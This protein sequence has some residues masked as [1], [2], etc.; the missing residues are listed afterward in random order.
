[1]KK[2]VLIFILI[3]VTSCKTETEKV[4]YIVFSG[5]ITNVGDKVFRLKPLDST[6]VDLEIKF[7]QNGAFRDTITTTKQRFVLFQKYNNVYFDLQP[8]DNFSMT[9]DGENFLETI[10]FNGSGADIINYN[11]G[12]ENLTSDYNKNYRDRFSVDESDFKKNAQEFYN[13]TLAYL[14]EYSK[15]SGEIVQREKNDLFY[16]YG[17]DL[18]RYTSNHPRLAEIE[19][20]EVTDEFFI[21]FN[22]FNWENEAAYESSA[23]YRYLIRANLNLNFEKAPKVEGADEMVELIEYINQ[24]IQNETI[25]NKL[26]MQN[27]TLNITYTEDLEGLYKAFCDG[28]TDTE[29]KAEITKIY[30]N[31]KK[32]AK[33]NPS[34]KFVDYENHSGG[35]TSLDDLKGK[36]VYVDVWATWCGPCKVEIPFLKEVEKKYHGKNIEFVSISV[37]RAPDHEKWIKMVNDEELGGIQLYADKDWNSDFVT[38]YYIKGI[39]RFILIDPNGLIIT[40]N[41]PRPS[42][43]KL[44]KLF[45]DLNI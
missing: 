10:N 32:L 1:M 17:L 34:P 16:S 5:T 7:D 3:A 27:S 29:L 15:L 20:F 26:L 22:D 28:I 39:P 9:A 38:G 21:D 31:L 24:N 41:A 11:I 13:K 19:N 8:G 18:F 40:A 36:Y 4:D 44:I 43:E 37:D 45:N 33:G 30:N 14:S 23:K 12:L 25:K 2:F 35:T 42:N 6:D